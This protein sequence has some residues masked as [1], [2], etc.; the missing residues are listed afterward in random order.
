MKYYRERSFTEAWRMGNIWV[1]DIRVLTNI[2][3]H[4]MIFFPQKSY[5]KERK[6]FITRHYMEQLEKVEI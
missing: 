4:W 6:A 3:H 1:T 2:K 5:D